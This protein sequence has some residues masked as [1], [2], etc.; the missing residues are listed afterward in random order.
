MHFHYF[1]PISLK[2]HYVVSDV[3]QLPYLSHF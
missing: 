2:K 3:V 1:S